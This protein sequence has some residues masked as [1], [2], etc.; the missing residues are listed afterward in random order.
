MGQ[1][2]ERTVQIIECWTSRPFPVLNL[3]TLVSTE[4]A[5]QYQVLNLWDGLLGTKLI[6]MLSQRSV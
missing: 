6:R 3:R 5:G 2:T 4:L 1:I